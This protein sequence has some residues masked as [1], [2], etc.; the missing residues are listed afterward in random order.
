MKP[1]L[2]LRY[3]R[4]CQQVRLWRWLLCASLAVVQKFHSGEIVLNSFVTHLVE[5]I[6]YTLEMNSNCCIVAGV[7]SVLSGF[8]SC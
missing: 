7:G 4:I 1:S 2:V 8:Q 6:V 5:S 3:D